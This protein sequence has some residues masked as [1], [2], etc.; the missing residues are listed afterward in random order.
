MLAVLVALVAATVVVVLL[1]NGGSDGPGDKSPGAS[2]SSSESSS[3]IPSGVPSELPSGIPTEI[4]T[5]LPSEVPSWL[6]SGIPTEIP[7]DLQSLFATPA[8]DEVPYYLLKKGDCFDTNADRL[9]Q[10]ARRSCAA[11]HEAEVVAITELRGTYATDSALR[12]AAAAL[13]E[14]PL[15]RGAADR[16]AGTVRGTLV[17]YPDQNT[18]K[19]GIDDVACSLAVDT[20]KGADKPAAH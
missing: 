15:E 7:S 1:V 13:C 16:P 5:A 10:A 14:T 11:P 9:G 8:N 19:V 17:Q 2:S 4:P 3:D 18:Y 20:G 12:R 6:P